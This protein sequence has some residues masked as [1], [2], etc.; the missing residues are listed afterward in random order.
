MLEYWEVGRSKVEGSGIWVNF[1]IKTKHLV[2][3]GESPYERLILKRI[4][5][6]DGAIALSMS[7]IFGI[8]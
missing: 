1:F 8:D 6:L 4:L 5:D 7:Q 2:I 3:K